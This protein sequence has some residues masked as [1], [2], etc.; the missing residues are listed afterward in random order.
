LSAIDEP[1][2][3][4][5]PGDRRRRGFLEFPAADDVGNAAGELELSARRKIGTGPAGGGIEREEA[6]IDGGDED[7]LPAGGSR[8]CRRRPKGRRSD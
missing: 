1:T 8:L 5:L 2:M 7:P 3:T 6:G 4:R